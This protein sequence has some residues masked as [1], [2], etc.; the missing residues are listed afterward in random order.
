MEPLTYLSSD[1]KY[2]LKFEG[3]G[4]YGARA[5][6]QN[7]ALMT[8]GFGPECE[9]QTLGFGK[10]RIEKGQAATS[11][12]L[13]ES[14]LSRIAEY[15]AWRSREFAVSVEEAAS[16]DLETMTQVNLER[17]FGHS[18]EIHLSV[19]RPATCDSRMQPHNW[20]VTDD[21]RWLKLD[22]VT[23]GDN[24]FFPGPCDIAWD[25][26]GAI[27]GWRMNPSAREFL[28]AEYRSLSGDDVNPRLPAYELAYA[29]FRFAWSATAAAS[30]PGK[31]DEERLLRDYRHH[32]KLAK[33]L[34][35]RFESRHAPAFRGSA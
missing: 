34:S 11:S 18:P 19:Q 20:F 4:Q 14:L 7:R 8:S 16:T 35:L 29:T 24:H 1:G 31:E 25:L 28:T 5:R 2:L 33:E 6:E 23:H 30:M 13:S 3:H 22:G 9:G 15:C 32:S 21:G 17:R 27:I 10:Q 12:D 26:A